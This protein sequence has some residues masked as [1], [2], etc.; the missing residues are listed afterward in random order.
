MP[1][2]EG[3]P[4]CS[5]PDMPSARARSAVVGPMQT[6]SGGTAS[7]AAIGPLQGRDRPRPTRRR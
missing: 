2:D 4:A 5:T 7:G 6:T 3:R 1:S